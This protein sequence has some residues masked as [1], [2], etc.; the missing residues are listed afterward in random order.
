MEGDPVHESA[1]TAVHDGLPTPV[2][3]SLGIL[4]QEDLCAFQT[5]PG[6]RTECRASLDLRVR[7]CLFP[8][9]QNKVH[10]KEAKPWR[11]WGPQMSS[12]AA[13]R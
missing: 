13:D 3:P 9:E 5:S 12:E 2:I 1:G 10:G 7:L 4:R 6:Y 8:K 11:H